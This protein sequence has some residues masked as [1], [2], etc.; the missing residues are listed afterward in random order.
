MNCNYRIYASSTNGYEQ[1]DVTRDEEKAIKYLD[2][3]CEKVLIVRHDFD[4]DCDEAYKLS[5]PE[6]K[7]KKKVKK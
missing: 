7:V 4:R 1:I 3:D 5:F 6:R 2:A